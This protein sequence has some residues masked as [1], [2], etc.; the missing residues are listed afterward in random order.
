[1]SL[2]QF[3]VIPLSDSITNDRRRICGPATGGCMLILLA[4][5]FKNL[6]LTMKLQRLK[7]S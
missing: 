4:G 1:M 2:L 7:I 6:E 5:K 3:C